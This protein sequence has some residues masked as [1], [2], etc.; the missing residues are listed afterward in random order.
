MH[1]VNYFN[2]LSVNGQLNCYVCTNCPNIDDLD[3]MIS[4]RCDVSPS[5]S[6]SPP[7]TPPTATP[8]TSTATTETSSMG[9]PSPPTPS[10][11][12]SA[13][14]LKNFTLVY[15]SSIKDENSD[16]PTESPRPPYRF[17][18]NQ[19][20]GIYQCFRIERRGNHCFFSSSDVYVFNFNAHYV[21][22]SW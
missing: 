20:S 22:Y 18:D 21:F 9:T 19:L 6:P 11:E 10:T 4:Q 15:E 3:E 14:P 12:A 2:S 5:P 1:S 7:N 16:K 17:I 8:S 13:V